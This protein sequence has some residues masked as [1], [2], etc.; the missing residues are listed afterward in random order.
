MQRGMRGLVGSEEHDV[1]VEIAIGDGALRLQECVLGPRRF[2]MLRDDVFGLRDRARRVAARNVAHGLHVRALFLE[3]VGR[4]LLCGLPG[5]M[6][7]GE[8]LIVD[9]D[10]LFRLFKRLRILCHDETDRV[11]EI[12]RQTADWDER[13][14]VVL[15]V[16]DFIL[17]GD[18]LGGQHGVDARHGQRLARVDGLDASARIFRADG[19]AIGHVGDVPVVGIFARAED[20]FLDV[21]PVDARADLPVVLARLRDDA[22]ALQLRRELHGGDDLHIARA[23]AVVVAQCVFDLFFVGVR[24]LIEQRLRADDHAGNAETALHGPGLAVGVG[25]ELLFLVRQAL[26]G[27]DVTAFE[28]IGGRRA[29]PAGLA[30][31]QNGTRAAR[32]LAASV[33]D[34]RQVQLVAQIAQQLLIFGDID[35]G[36]IDKKHS[37]GTSLLFRGNAQV[38]NPLYCFFRTLATK[39]PEIF[40]WRARICSI[41]S[42]IREKQNFSRISLFL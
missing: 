13:I 42:K 32:A 20:L 28:R 24:V 11:A 40:V 33:L 4:V 9:L 16:A 34:A 17:A 7:R 23:A 22:L 37:H 5:V 18:V 41:I 27:Q 19:G 39:V 2:K 1:A 36:S 26:D 35:F 8:D 10:E 38:L 30:V 6:Y 15:D 21:E 12:V 3:D 31:D 25:V 29:G 14:L